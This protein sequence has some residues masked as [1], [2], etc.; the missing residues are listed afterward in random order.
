MED[1]VISIA[2]QNSPEIDNL[3]KHKFFQKMVKECGDHLSSMCEKDDD[4]V[5]VSP[6]NDDLPSFGGGVNKHNLDKSNTLRSSASGQMYGSP[7]PMR[8]SKSYD[9]NSMSLKSDDT[10]TRVKNNVSHSQDVDLSFDRSLESDKELKE[11]TKSEQQDP[12][13]KPTPQELVDE[14]LDDDDPG[15]V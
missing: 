11:A 14:F 2:N 12:L 10:I 5:T 8:K 15:Y 1:E 4:Q 3:M 9:N 7:E 13:A 6:K